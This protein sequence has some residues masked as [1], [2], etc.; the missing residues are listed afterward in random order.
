[1]RPP[2]AALACLVALLGLCP[3]HAA[4][5][6]GHGSQA[7]P[8]H[9]RGR[10]STYGEPERR[11]LASLLLD[12]TQYGDVQGV[13]VLA[14]SALYHGNGYFDEHVL[15]LLEGRAYGRA[16]LDRAGR[17]GWRLETVPAI[18]PAR[19]SPR[20]TDRFAKLHVLNL[21]R[22]GE[23]VY[24]DPDA[25]FVDTLT[26][27]FTPGNGSAGH[28]PCRL[29]AGR[30]FQGGRFTDA[31]STGV[32]VLRPNQ[33]EL[34]RLVDLLQAGAVP[35]EDG[36]A[37]EQGFLNAVYQG[38]WCE[39]DFGK[40]ADV[41]V[42]AAA[43]AGA[44]ALE[45]LWE[46]SGVEVVRFTTRAPWACDAANAAYC[47]LWRQEN[48]SA[49]H[50]LTVV[51][52]YYAGPAKH[53]EEEYALWSANFMRMQAPV[54]LFTDDLTAIPGLAS[55]A[56]D[57]IQVV[58]KTTAAF[59]VSRSGFDW[60]AQLVLDPERHVHSAHLFRLWLEKSFFVGQAMR[61]NP[62]WSTHFVW[63]DY[64][65]FRTVGAPPWAPRVTYLPP[66]KILLLNTSSLHTM[67]LKT[68][69]GG[70]IGGDARAWRAW[71]PG[72]DSVIRSMYKHGEFIGDDQIPMT[73][74]V[75]AHSNLTCVMHPGPD[76][77]DPWFAM[78][79]VVA[80]R[81]GREALRQCL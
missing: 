43:Q 23:V 52:A 15:L 7:R 49:V 80:G 26:A 30:H 42:H 48:R 56:A 4:Q 51:S 34:A 66:S 29:W 50:P 58:H 13:E 36:E 78:G 65:F 79:G 59:H 46:A 25:A 10:A 70:L 39:L 16:A 18:T 8:T 20:R 55:R 67:S 62:F 64:G 22:C 38:A 68:V 1:M 9:V 41:A 72:F 17:A 3:T 63:V 75:K 45:R 71:I 37:A 81:V 76:E 44:A 14:K 32:A 5:P 28:G 60:D 33:T 6:A 2:V 31:F 35:Y 73:R 77:K 69:G 54:V 24:M 47:R 12:T 40:A 11:C 74:M 21:T 53:S 27:P 57:T 19:S 61:A